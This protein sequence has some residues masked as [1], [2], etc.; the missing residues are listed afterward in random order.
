MLVYVIRHGQSESNLSRTY[1]D[2]VGVHLTEKGIEDAKRAGKVLA[3]VNFTHIYASD[4]IRAIETARNALPGCDPVIDKRLRELS[5]GRL[6][7]MGIA[8]SKEHLGPEF[9]KGQ[10]RRDYSAYGGES[11]EQQTER[12]ASFMK[13]LESLDPDSVVAVFCHAGTVKCFL[14]VV[15]GHQ[16]DLRRIACDNGSVAVFGFKDGTWSLKKWNITG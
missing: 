14:N 7:G 1:P 4:L 8:Y 5:Y 11:T 10:A 15:F 12:V 3:P 9:L 16:L 2:I 13:D 6:A